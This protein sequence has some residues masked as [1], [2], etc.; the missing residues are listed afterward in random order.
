VE[1]KVRKWFPVTLIIVLLIALVG[2]LILYFTET[3]K[4]KK[5]NDEIASQKTYINMVR[6]P[7]HFKTL[8]DLKKWLLED[9]VNTKYAS[10]PAVDRAYILE[11]RAAQDGFILPALYEQDKTDVTKIYFFNMANIAGKIYVINSSND[12]VTLVNTLKDAPAYRPL[13]PATTTPK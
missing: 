13:V 9:D 3:G 4:L 5:A 10:V 7:S 12:A 11:I 8:D 2:S 6:Y 1:E